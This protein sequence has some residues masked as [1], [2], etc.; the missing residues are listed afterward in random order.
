MTALFLSL[1]LILSLCGTAV[2]EALTGA[3][4]ICQVGE[5]ET[6]KEFATLAE[7][8]EAIEATENQNGIIT[9]LEDT[10][11]DIV[12][13]S[14]TI[15][16]NLNGK[17]ITSETVNTADYLGTVTVKG[18]QLTVNDESGNGEIRGRR[19][20]VVVQGG[21]LTVNGGTF[22][23]HNRTQN[24]NDP[25]N[26]PLFVGGGSAVINGG[27]FADGSLEYYKLYE[28]AGSL[29]VN[30]GR[31]DS[32]P[33]FIRK[34][35]TAIWA[36][37]DEGKWMIAYPTYAAFAEDNSDAFIY[38]EATNTLTM[39]S[40]FQ[41][42]ILV[43]GDTGG[44]F[45]N[46]DVTVD[47][48]GH[49][50]K[51]TYESQN[52]RYNLMVVNGGVELTLKDSS[53]DGTG[54]I[55]NENGNVI[56]VMGTLNLQGGTLEHNKSMIMAP[57]VVLDG[58]STVNMSGGAV[59]SS[60]VGFR[61]LK[62]SDGTDN[63]K[64]QIR[65]T[66]GTVETQSDGI[67]LNGR[68]GASC[69]ISGGTFNQAPDEAWCANNYVFI[70]DENGKYTTKE[71]TVTVAAVQRTDGTSI[72]YT[73]FGKALASAQE[74]DV[75]CLCADIALSSALTVSNKVTLDLAGH[76]VTQKST[77]E[78]DYVFLSV[79]KSGDLTITDSENGGTLITVGILCSGKITIA[80]G[81]ISNSGELGA[82]N[83]SANNAEA[84]ISGG[85]LQSGD[86]CIYAS[87]RYKVLVDV[88]GG[89]IRSETGSGI[90]VSKGSLSVS[91]GHISGTI[92]VRAGYGTRGVSGEVNAVISKDADIT[93]ETNGIEL[94]GNGSS[95]SILGGTVTGKT[96]KG[97]SADTSACP[98]TVSVQGGE[99]SGGEYG[100]FVSASTYGTDRS[101]MVEISG[102]VFKGNAAIGTG[103][104]SPMEIIGGIF[105]TDVSAYCTVEHYNVYALTEGE[106]N[107]YYSVHSHDKGFAETKTEKDNIIGATCT[108][109]GS[110]EEIV[111]CVH[112]G[113][114]FS[115]TPVGGEQAKGHT[116]GEWIEE[117]PATCT[118]EGTK[119]HYHCSACGKD[120]DAD[121]KELTD[122][123]IAVAEHD[124]ETDFT[125]DTEAT[126]TT[127]G[128]KSIHCRNCDQKKE[129]TVIPAAGHS[130]GTEWKHDTR[131]HWHECTCG[132][133]TDA[134]AHTFVWIT[135]Q[136]G[137]QLTLHPECAVC[138]ERKGVPGDTNQNGVLDA[139]DCII[140]RR[141]FFE[142]IPL[143]EE[144]LAL[145]D[146]NGNGRVDAIECLKLR[147]AFFGL[148]P[149]NKLFVN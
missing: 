58:N 102:G 55:T 33:Y 19:F 25:W 110:Y 31:F 89:S 96:Q 68:V 2:A 40:D 22:G 76:K 56:E 107:G 129:V 147:R 146:F 84:H 82:I 93:G 87:Y 118:A 64:Q 141:A 7:A 139:S 108:E 71:S 104:S 11:E 127:D 9:L 91:G 135:D 21:L 8:I 144:Q 128:S 38:D 109:N 3:S 27:T 124:W 30:G 45:F 145:A 32:L 42:P 103:N 73:T 83:L 86:H 60:D 114:E 136:T 77:A 122:L 51:L 44:V 123:T 10:T 126:C 142:L 80:G 66:G 70:T 34:G 36:A 52:Y 20:A 95:L 112:C 15:V 101:S 49:T 35:G 92:G 63:T 57:A 138:G 53:S 74:G 24:W 97:V 62:A 113:H 5:G 28:E 94:W 1:L 69:E 99:I 54:K 85:T 140:I 100:L 132:D 105:S 65:I 59:V 125:V 6:A 12:I 78:E 116:Y 41:K 79:E 46:E 90:Y 17:K 23:S 81:S 117:I 37:D 131:N 133:R 43:P 130:Y 137:N 120:Y 50:W 148:I 16:L 61:V 88:T 149:L 13:S 14:G 72:P 18:G 26:E 29:T 143:T 47:L 98:N 75:V 121:K 119:G 48:A 115:R 4:P 106:Y 39:K 134:D 67:D 111:I